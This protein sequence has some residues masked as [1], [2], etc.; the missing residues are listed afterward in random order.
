MLSLPRTALFA[1]CCVTANVLAPAWAAQS[2]ARSAFGTLPGGARVELFTLTNA[3]GT[4]V[5]VLDYGGIITSIKVPDRRGTLGDVVLGYGSLEGYVENP[6]YMGALVGRYANR[7]GKAQFTL[8]GTTYTLAVNNGENSLHGG[9]K[10]FDKAVWKATPFER[11]GQVGVT[12]THTSPDGDEGYPGALSLHVTYTLNV[13]NELTLDYS[14]TTDKATVLNLTHHDYF[15]LAGEGSGDV[16]GHRVQLFAKRFTPVDTNL[17]PS[18]TAADVAGTPFDFRKPTRLGTRIRSDDPQLKL[19]GGYDHNFVIDHE[20]KALAV[21]ARVE[22]PNSGRVLEVRTTEPGVQFYTA[23]WLDVVGKDG[24]AY[25]RNH[26]F[27]LETQHFPDSPN[28]PSFPTTTLRPGQT[29]HST[30]VYAFSVK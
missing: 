15:N 29:F 10:G 12:L 17:I 13:S 24:H 1:F 26:A 9:R 2:V 6:S 7:I 18:G 4:E 21:A 27:C 22:E 28:K 19:A 20:G 16:L 3:K 14:A 8:D 5:R 11:P 30:T 25:Q 23:N